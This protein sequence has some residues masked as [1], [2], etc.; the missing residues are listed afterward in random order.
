MSLYPRP[1]ASPL[2]RSTRFRKM[3]ERWL[4]TASFCGLSLAACQS[5]TDEPA[6]SGDG[7]GDGDESPG[8]GDGTVPGAGGGTSGDGDLIVTP[9][10]GSPGDGDGLG[11]S[12]PVCESAS[13]EAE[14]APIFLA[15]AFDVSGS[16]G[17]YD[18]PNWWH[19]PEA[20][21]IPVRQATSAFFEDASSIGISASMT[22]FPANDDV[23]ESDTYLTPDVAMIALP[24]GDFSGAL[25]GYE[26]EVG[27]PL[28]GGDWRGNTPTLAAF[29]GTS[30]YLGTFQADNPEAE[31]AVVLVTDGLPQGCD[32][33]ENEVATVSA[34]V[35][36]LYESG[37]RTYVI[38]IENPTVPPAVLPGDWEDWGEDCGD[39]PCTPPNTLDALHEVATAGG[40]GQAFLID[41]GDPSA[42]QA[43]LRQ[44]IDAIRSQSISCELGIPPNP[45]GGSF[46]P[47]KIDVTYT[48][49]GATTRFNFDP[50]CQEPGSWHYDDDAN[51]ASIQLCTDACDLVQSLPGAQLDVAF[52]CEDRPDVVR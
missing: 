12:G 9:S 4:I 44:A 29:L 36:A 47:D 14:L 24:S 35:A 37:I 45:N 22:F 52:L 46:D 16:M 25:D 50:S 19:D 39:A 27:M 31:T 51:P 43:A 30:E 32:D 42:T 13:S 28:A 5:D 34:A 21:W 17:K 20:K 7:D 18:R 3:A 2:R 48:V 11:G 26:A 6:G 10:G 23:C 38:G 8:D 15:F 1:S 40:T 49:E 33:E 41:T